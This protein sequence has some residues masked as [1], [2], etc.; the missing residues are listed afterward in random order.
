MVCQSLNY[1]ADEF[2]L[3]AAGFI[4]SNTASRVYTDYYVNKV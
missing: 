4:Y 1:W 2:Y 3:H